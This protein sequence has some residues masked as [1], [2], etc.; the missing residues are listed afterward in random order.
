M[1]A[2][3]WSVTDCIVALHCVAAPLSALLLLGLP[4]CKLCSGWSPGHT[5][6]MRLPAYLPQLGE[7]LL[8]ARQ[9]VT[10]GEDTASEISDVSVI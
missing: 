5:Q 6:R 3:G 1:L 10:A 8:L 7:L 4:A 9:P 2:S